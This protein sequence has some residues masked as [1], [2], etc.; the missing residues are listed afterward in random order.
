MLRIAPKRP[1]S[2]T[3]DIKSD[4]KST[5][6]T[7]SLIADYELL[8]T[9]KESLVRDFANPYLELVRL[10]KESSEI[11]HA[12]MVQYLYATFSIKQDFQALAGIAYPGSTTLLGVAIQEMKHL[13]SVNKFLVKLGILPNLN[14]QD[15]PYEPA[16]Y[17]FEFNLEPLS[18]KT[19]AKY[20]YTESSAQE[21]DPNNPSNI[22]D[23]Q[24]IN[25]LYS[26]IGTNARINHLGSLY[27][28]IIEIATEVENSKYLSFSIQSNIDEMT[29]IKDQGES[30]HFNFF[31]SVF[32]GTHNTLATIPNI[33]DLPTNDKN[34]PANLLPR[35]PSAY[36]G[37]PNQIQN[38]TDRQ[39]AWLGNIHYWLILLLLHQSYIDTSNF[40]MLYDLA[41]EQ[42][43]SPLYSIGYGLAEKQQGIPFD[44][45]S[46][47]YNIGIDIKSNLNIIRLLLNEG[48]TIA[49]SLAAELP[50]SFP[51]DIYTASLSRLNN[52][53]NIA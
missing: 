11:E 6:Q 51:N 20:V 41:K 22:N 50:E 19:C 40:S 36:Y 27:H 33:W 38:E 37:H 24:F 10:L 12:L 25:K 23:I 44:V 48:K 9:Q 43:I 49:D 7:A 39:I 15:F 4:F 47:G 8:D 2:T 16:I 32:C 17:P 46:L 45:L 42:M 1:V 35:N 18:I 14:R 21:I 53:L 5:E 34:Y 29:A 30:E 31:K 28:T 52:T 26:V 3:F 13:H